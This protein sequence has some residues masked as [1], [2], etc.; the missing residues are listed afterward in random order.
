MT[1]K[2]KRQAHYQANKEKILTERKAYYHANKDKVAERNKQWQLAN[3]DKMRKYRSAWSNKTVLY[4]S[5]NNA[6]RRAREYNVPFDIHYTDLVMPEVCP[7]LGVQFDSDSHEYRPSIDRVVPSLGYIL[8][9][10]QI[11]SVR[12]NRLKS[13]ANV[14]E[15]RKVLAY[16][17]QHG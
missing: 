12:A 2:E 11:I 6:K 10:I 15:L 17:E 14:D 16:V 9:N 7:V 4:N 3:A 13:D 5:W 8:G 1:N